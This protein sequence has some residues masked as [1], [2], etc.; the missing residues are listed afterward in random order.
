MK[1]RGYG[2]K[3]RTSFSI[4]TFD[5]RDKI[6]MGIISLLGGIVMLGAIRGLFY[7]RYFPTMKGVN[8][9]VQTGLFFTV[10][11]MLCLTPILINL[12]EDWRWTY[13]QSKI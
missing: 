11:F 13:T 4:F 1:S 10:Y 3:G 5:K 6:T 8:L 2:L 7:Y 12:W 9:T